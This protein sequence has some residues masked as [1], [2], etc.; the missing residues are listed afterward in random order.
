MTNLKGNKKDKKPRTYFRGTRTAA[1]K[2]RKESLPT[3]PNSQ[4]TT[5]A[6]KTP[7]APVL[8]AWF[9]PYVK[10]LTETGNKVLACAK[11]GIER[12]TPRKYFERNPNPEL[13]D[14]IEAAV[15]EGHETIVALYYR[16]ALRGS[17]KAQWNIIQNR[18]GRFRKKLEIE[19][20]LTVK[21]VSKM[22]NE[23]L[24]E[25]ERKIKG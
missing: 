25:Y 15:N 1:S 6:K 16:K 11:V 3:S 9:N 21:D 13:E 20:T 5:R 8:P 12:S 4:K 7:A 2:R 18:V 14:A 17:E 10:A 24:L 23:E 22:T 19:G